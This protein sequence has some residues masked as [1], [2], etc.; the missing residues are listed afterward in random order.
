[1][2]YGGIGMLKIC[3]VMNIYNESI[4]RKSTTDEL[5]NLTKALKKYYC[6]LPFRALCIIRCM[7]CSKNKLMKLYYHN[8]LAKKY[9]CDISPEAI[10]GENFSIAHTLGVVI[11]EGVE[12]G[13]NVKVFQNV[14]L[15]QKNGKYPIIGNNV[16][17]YAGAKIIGD[18]KIGDGAVVGANAVV[19]K[20]VPA[21]S[22]VAGVPARVI[23]YCE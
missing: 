19:T 10:I 14:T 1:M 2:Q 17:I 22:V 16:T 3:V 23:K 21:N 20:D 5:V 6:E 4:G 7:R 15:G 9:S 18:V 12:I 8:K 11:G 13:H